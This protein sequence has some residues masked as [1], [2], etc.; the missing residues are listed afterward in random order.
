M[1]KSYFK[2]LMQILIL[3]TK[4]YYYNLFTLNFLFIKLSDKKFFYANAI[5]KCLK[6]KICNLYGN[7]IFNTLNP[8]YVQNLKT[9]QFLSNLNDL[10]HFLKKLG[11]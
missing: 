11:K 7:M 1:P 3:K 2:N 10:K 9:M 6:R 5:L 8:K 4:I